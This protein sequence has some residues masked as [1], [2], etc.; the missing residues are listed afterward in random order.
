MQHQLIKISI[1]MHN[2]SQSVRHI[3]GKPNKSSS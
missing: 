1:T 2:A 3:L